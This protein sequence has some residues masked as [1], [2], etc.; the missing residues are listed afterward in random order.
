MKR[1][2]IFLAVSFLITWICWGI[3][4]PPARARTI[5]YGSL[6]F[7]L[8]Y[9]F[10]GLGPTIAA[11]VAVLATRA[12]SPLK[13]FHSRLFRW[14]VAGW[15][16]LIALALPV[17]LALASV[18]IAVFVD[19][20]FPKGLSVR[21]WYMFAPLFL[22][23][24][25]GGGLEELGWRGVA[26]PEMER[27]AGRPAAAVLVGLIWSLWHLPLFI[28]PGVGQ[29]GDNF[30]VFAIGIVGGALILA[31]LYGR[32]ESILLCVLFHAGWN[33][34]AALG[35]AVPPARRLPAVLDACLR[36]I[37]GALLLAIGSA[38]SNKRLQATTSGAITEHG[39]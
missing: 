3:L 16:Y 28:L 36:L 20:D 32:T 2:V 27:R 39:D 7:M 15:W 31:W 23:M 38:R 1:L 34:V 35:L 18:G 33:A 5:A 21:P 14:R 29:Y 12:Q 26:Q 11:Y 37:V 4:V 8:L 6:P 13:E 17:A 25:A 19:P 22:V 30:P 10:G 24:V 9:M